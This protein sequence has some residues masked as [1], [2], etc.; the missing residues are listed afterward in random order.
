[1][2]SLLVAYTKNKRVIGAQGKIPWNLPSERNRFKDICR[3]KY[4]IMGRKSYEE[5][6]HPLSYCN[7]VVVSSGPSRASGTTNSTSG[8]TNAESR[9]LSLSKGPQVCTSLEDAINYCKSQNQEEILI[10]GGESIY[11]QSLPYAGKIYATEI[12][13][14]FDG[15]RYFPELGA[16]WSTTIDETH[17]DN[18]ITYRYLTITSQKA[19]LQ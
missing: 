4:V 8:T 19:D 12:D 7:L 16:E 13:A 9:S 10:A 14:N 6:G 17:E 11:R 1:M 2:I 18:G 15:D 5:I 3:G